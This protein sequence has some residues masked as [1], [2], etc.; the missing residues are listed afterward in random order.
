MATVAQV[1]YVAPGPLVNR[2]TGS[3]KSKEMRQLCFA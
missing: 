2:S 3:S 1:S